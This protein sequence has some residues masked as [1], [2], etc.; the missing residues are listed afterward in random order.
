MAP[1]QV[2]RSAISDQPSAKANT[3]MDGAAISVG[4]VAVLAER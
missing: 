1:P 3:A 2:Q 4:F